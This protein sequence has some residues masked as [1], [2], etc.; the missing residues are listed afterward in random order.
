[1]AQIGQI[2]RANSPLDLVHPGPNPIP[3]VVSRFAI[4]GELK[5]KCCVP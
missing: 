2:G 3:R 1:V 4:A 5:F